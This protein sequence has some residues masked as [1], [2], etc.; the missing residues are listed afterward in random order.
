MLAQEFGEVENARVFRDASGVSKGIG[1]VQ[2]SNSE[3]AEAAI[4]GMNGKLVGLVPTRVSGQGI[5]VTRTEPWRC[6]QIPEQISS[7][8]VTRT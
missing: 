8:T 6:K 7:P 2:F 3:D 4:T 5:C 1:Q